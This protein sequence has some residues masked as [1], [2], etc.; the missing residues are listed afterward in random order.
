MWPAG[1]V[2]IYVGLEHT[3]EMSFVENKYMVQALFSYTSD[4]SFC[5]RIGIGCFN[6][7]VDDLDLLRLKYIVECFSQLLVIVMNQTTECLLSFLDSPDVLPG[8]LGHPLAIWIGSAPS[9]MNPYGSD[10]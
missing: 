4:P 8:L 9:K 10:L 7:G 6:G 5:E 1:V 3:T 2:V